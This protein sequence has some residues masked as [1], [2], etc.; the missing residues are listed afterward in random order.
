MNSQQERKSGCYQDGHATLPETTRRA[1][2]LDRPYVRPGVPRTGPGEQSPAQLSALHG[3][4]AG[5]GEGRPGSRSQNAGSG[6]QLY[7]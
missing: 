5:G 6:P 1:T 2:A 7:D 4:P 3:G